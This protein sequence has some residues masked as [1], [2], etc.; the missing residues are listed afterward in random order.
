MD[1]NYSETSFRRGMCGLFTWVSFHDG[2][3]WIQSPGHLQGAGDVQLGFE[4][5]NVNNNVAHPKDSRCVN[6][7][8]A[9]AFSTLKTICVALMRKTRAL[10]SFPWYAVIWRLCESDESLQAMT[11]TSCYTSMKMTTMPP[12]KLQVS[13]WFNCEDWLLLHRTGNWIQLNIW[14]QLQGYLIVLLTQNPW[15]REILIVA[16]NQV[17]CCLSFGDTI[18]FQF[19]VFI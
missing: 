19:S 11:E 3:H 14:K 17:R 13:K 10:R 16:T 4:S 1:A 5:F 2:I 7:T 6:A 8:R 18:G 9:T 15:H 12:H